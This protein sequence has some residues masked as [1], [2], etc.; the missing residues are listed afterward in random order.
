MPVKN[1][2]TDIG[3]DLAS[4]GDVAGLLDQ[5]VISQNKTEAGPLQINL[6]LVDEDPNQPRHEFE[7]E[8]MQELADSIKER[9]VKTP[10]S[11]HPHPIDEGRY[12]INHGA[13]RFRASKIAGKKTIPAFIDIDY[14]ED[15]QV[16]ENLQRDDLTP[17]EIAEYIGRKLKEG[18]KKNEIAKRLSKSNAFITQHATLLNLPELVENVFNSGRCEDVTVVNELVKAYKKEP[19]QVETWLD[20]DEQDITRGTV[21][22]L[23]DFLDDKQEME[24]EEKEEKTGEEKEEKKEPKEEDPNKLKKAIVLV[25]H[26]G[27]EARLILNKRPS[28]DGYSWLKYE[29]DGMEFETDLGEV[30]LLSLI[31]G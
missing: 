19:E 13:R 29:D 2:K 1:E 24:S 10:I 14:T 3:L 25:S 31:E 28:A 16:I 6:T 4:L 21:K 5:P 20:D 7:S 17:R 30:Q 27:R 18:I 11:V 9:G 26:D 22:L 8:K 15:D 12:I 23:R